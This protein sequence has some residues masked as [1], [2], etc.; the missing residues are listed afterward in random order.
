MILWPNKE[1]DD[2]QRLMEWADSCDVLGHV[3]IQEWVSTDTGSE[4]PPGTPVTCSRCGVILSEV[5]TA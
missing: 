1:W 4:P 3:P 2:L 5:R